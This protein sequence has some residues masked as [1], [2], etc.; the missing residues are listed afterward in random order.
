[1]TTRRKTEN[2]KKSIAV[3]RE[4]IGI[5]DMVLLSSTK[6]NIVAD[7]LKLRLESQQ[8]YSYIGDVLVAC[9]PYKW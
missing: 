2:V 5:E 6:E 8:I 1:M 9:N 4:I 7:N 3:R